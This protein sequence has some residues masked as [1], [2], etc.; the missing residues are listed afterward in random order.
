M[1]PPELLER[2]SIISGIGQSDV[3]R[4][5]DGASSTSPS[6]P[7]CR[8]SPTPGSAATTSTGWP[9]SPAPGVGTGGFAG[10]PTPEVQ[11]A[12]RLKLNWHDG[13]L[14]GPGQLRAVFAACL[15]VAAGLA[16]HVL[17]Y[18]TVTESIAQGQGGRQG[19]GGGGG[20]RGASPASRARC[21]GRSPTARC[22]PPT[23]WP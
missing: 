4:A 3:G 10:P 5:S 11:D 17:V 19:I 18:R 16:R 6:T 13:G 15:A 9:P 20:G 2:R 12:L 23:G 8:P 22:R 1:S 14:E 21:S 7:A